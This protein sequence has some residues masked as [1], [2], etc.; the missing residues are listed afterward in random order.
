MITFHDI[1]QPPAYWDEQFVV[2]LIDDFV[3]CLEFQDSSNQNISLNKNPIGYL[4][5]RKLNRNKNGKISNSVHTQTAFTVSSQW[6]QNSRSN[7]PISHSSI[8]NSKKSE[9]SRHLQQGMALPLSNAS[10]ENATA[11]LKRNLRLFPLITP[12]LMTTYTNRHRQNL[13]LVTLPIKSSHRRRAI[14][15]GGSRT[16]KLM[17]SVKQFQKRRPHQNARQPRWRRKTRPCF[18]R[19]LEKSW[20][21]NFWQRLRDLTGISHH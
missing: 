7:K 19:T 8:N 16:K 2:A 13:Q 9:M 6:F 21:L 1:S 4:G 15:F 11:A 18:V 17:P 3:T 10:Q 20:K 5:T 14:L 12:R